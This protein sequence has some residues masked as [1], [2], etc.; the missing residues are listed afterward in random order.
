MVSYLLKGGDA[1]VK[2]RKGRRVIKLN[3]GLKVTLSS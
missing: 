3:N 2:A 1:I